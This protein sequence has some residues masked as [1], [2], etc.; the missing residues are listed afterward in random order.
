VWSPVA[1][2][3][4]S[5]RR[6]RRADH[7]PSVGFPVIGAVWRNRKKWNFQDAAHYTVGGVPA[8]GMA[9][10]SGGS[11]CGRSSA[12]GYAVTTANANGS[13]GIRIVRP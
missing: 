8:G 5:A 9:H 2:F 10:G 12:I 13:D 11:N 7:Y 6:S 3:V 1:A 4:G